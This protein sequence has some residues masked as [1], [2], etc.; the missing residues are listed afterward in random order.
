MKLTE[1]ILE[2]CFDSGADQAEV[3]NLSQKR[4]SISVRDGQVET[5]E[6]STPGG[7]AIRFFINGKSAF[8][9]MTDL[10]DGAIKN[11]ISKL[12][13]LT[14]SVETDE[15]AILP[16]PGDDIGD[17]DVYDDSWI[18]SPIDQKIEYLKKLE[19]L[20]LNY[21][22]LIKQ[23]GWINYNEIVTTKT[24]SNSHGINKSYDSTEYGIGCS[25]IAVKGDE[26][27][28]GE[29]YMSARY[30]ND[31]PTAEEIVDKCASRAIRLI[32]G[33]E[34]ESGD[35]EIIF[36]KGG[37]GSLLWGFNFAL[38]GEE[39]IK[40]SSFLAGKLNQKIASEKLSLIN[41][42]TIKR[43]LAS[44]PVDDEGVTS[45]KT[46]FVDNG[47]LTG[48]MYDTKT[49]AKAN[50][51]STSSSSRENYNV[52]PG[53]WPSNFYFAP[54]DDKFEDVVASCKKGIIVEATHGWGLHSVT[55][56]YSAGINGTLVRNGQRI[57]SVANVTIAGD[58]E[59]IL[60]GIGAVCDDITFHRQFNSPSIMIK[61]MKVGS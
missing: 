24:I 30:F 10:T 19:T 2:R 57:K 51:E 50:T 38:N 59:S 28:S 55:G 26:K 47:I 31:L 53:I 7:L 22:P 25:L 8:G 54:S 16:K 20:G 12:R 15:F 29:T 18:N 43:G 60:N 56:N 41:D 61:S 37:A 4:T 11:L 27:F 45:K 3:F 6:K 58:A 32:G 49:A 17:L 5:I 40:G 46:V 35:Y 9:H 1:S 14:N 52:N 44:K 21:D 36:T 23:A 33:T 13:R 34:I 48:F 39:V 42:P